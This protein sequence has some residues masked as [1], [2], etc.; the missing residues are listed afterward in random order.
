MTP[1]STSSYP[2]Y[3]PASYPSYPPAQY[4]ALQLA[5]TPHTR[6]S[7]RSIWHPRWPLLAGIIYTP[8]ALIGYGFKVYYLSPQSQACAFGQLCYIE[9]LPSSEQVALI[10]LGFLV[11]WTLVYLLGR[12]ALGGPIPPRPYTLAGRLYAVSQFQPARH[13]LGIFGLAALAGIVVA[14]VERQTDPAGFAMAAIVIFV[15]ARVLAYGPPRAT[16][17]VTPGE[18][19]RPLAARLRTGAPRRGV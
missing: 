17:Q 8:A 12:K 16:L 4:Q 19:T 9:T 15:A 13:I 11:L 6:Q 1:E 14:T 10:W 7:G 2:S 18:A 5:S 3:P